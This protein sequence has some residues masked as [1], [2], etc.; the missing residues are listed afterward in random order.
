M[1]NDTKEF[2]IEN[3][4]LKR[5]TGPGGDVVIPDGVTSIGDQA[6][7]LCGKMTS[8]TMPDSVTQI[9]DDAFCLCDNLTSVTS[10][11]SVS[12][13]LE[14]M[15]PDNARFTDITESAHALLKQQSRRRR[16]PVIAF[17]KTCVRGLQKTHGFVTNS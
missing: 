15:A 4:V 1:M 17:P 13:G 9:G 5:Y 8:V 16:Y 2:E 11:N 12:W 7:Y 3:G 6:F 10:P 14:N